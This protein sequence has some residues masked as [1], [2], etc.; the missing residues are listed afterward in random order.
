MLKYEGIIFRMGDCILKAIFI[1]LLWLIGSLPMITIGAATTAAYFTS[2]K[3]AE[4]EDV[5]VLP[6]FWRSYKQNLI[7]SIILL[8]PFLVIGI[9]MICFYLNTNYFT[10][11]NPTVSVGYLMFTIVWIILTISVFP[12]L[13]KFNMNSI[14]IFKSSILLVYKQK[15][16]ITKV[17]FLFS[18]LSFI[19]ILMPQYI[20]FMIGGY[21]MIAGR[22]YHQAFCEIVKAY[23]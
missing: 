3:L 14:Q 7:Q 4:N 13:S 20:I 10:Q 16:I 22:W 18:L 6:N 5:K 11:L 1:G 15:L 17:I 21:F 8:L 23:Q 12:I 9:G 19:V 2:I